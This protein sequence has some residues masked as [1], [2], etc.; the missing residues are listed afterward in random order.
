MKYFDHIHSHYLCSFPIHPPIG[1]PLYSS[2]FF[3]RTSHCHLYQDSQGYL[4]TT[5]SETSSQSLLHSWK[6]CKLCPP[7]LMKTNPGISG[8]GSQHWITSCSI[9]IVSMICMPA[10]TLFYVNFI[11]NFLEICASNLSM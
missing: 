4:D 7:L 5:L 1:Q 6:T 10:Q 9:F 8:R 11:L 3:Q 2:L